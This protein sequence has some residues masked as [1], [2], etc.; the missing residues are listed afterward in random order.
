METQCLPTPPAHVSKT[1]RYKLNTT[2]DLFDFVFYNDYFV[3]KKPWY[4]SGQGNKQVITMQV[5]GCIKT[6]PNTLFP[7]PPFFFNKKKAWFNPGLGNIQSSTKVLA[8]L[9]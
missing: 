3:N 9:R 4:C 8:H 2:Y 5:Y 7:Y 6:K 1:T